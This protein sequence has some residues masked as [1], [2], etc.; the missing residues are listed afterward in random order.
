MSTRQRY[1]LTVA[2]ER[3]GV[4]LY[5]FQFRADEVGWQSREPLRKA[6][7]VRLDRADDFEPCLFRLEKEDQS[8]RSSDAR[9]ILESARMPSTSAASDTGR[10]IR[11]PC[12]QWRRQTQHAESIWRSGTLRRSGS[13]RQSGQRNLDFEDPRPRHIG[14]RFPNAAGNSRVETGPSSEQRGYSNS[15]SYWDYRIRPRHACMAQYAEARFEV[16]ADARHH[17]IPW[18]R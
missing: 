11:L 8:S 15:C 18:T 1:L 16:K 5:A 7:A 6:P 13:Y 2:T 9:Y 4:Q 3:C 12:L 10:C 17:H 14:N